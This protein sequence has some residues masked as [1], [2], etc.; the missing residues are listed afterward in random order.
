M[1]RKT[2]VADRWR[3]QL[4]LRPLTLVLLAVCV[5]LAACSR[6]GHWRTAERGSAGIAPEVALE[7]AAVLV[8]A[9]ATYGWRGYFADHTWVA[10]KRIGDADYEIY[11]VLGWRAYRGQPVV[12]VSRGEPDRYWYGSKPR[13]LA[14]M[15]GRQVESIIDKIEQAVENYPWPNQYRIFPGPNSNTFTAWIAEQ[16]PELSL[17]MPLRA[18]GKGY[19][20]SAGNL[21]D[22]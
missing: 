19:V 7:E 13:E 8:Y 10:T 1:D 20:R 16:V 14:R 12:S 15:Q 21:S 4:R 18:V 17:H 11:E 22:G 6:R 3:S 9:A 5:S 2:S